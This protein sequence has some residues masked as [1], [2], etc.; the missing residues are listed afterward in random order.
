MT[1]QLYKVLRQVTTGW[2]LAD[3]RAQNLTKQQC[4]EVLNNIS[5]L[6][7]RSHIYFR[8]CSCSSP[9][10]SRS[11]FTRKLFYGLLGVF[12]INST[13]RSLH[14]LIEY[15][16]LLF[17]LTFFGSLLPFSHSFSTVFF[18]TFLESLFWTFFCFYF[19][20]FCLLS[21]ILSSRKLRD[22]SPTWYILPT[23]YSFKSCFLI[24]FRLLPF[25]LFSE[26]TFKVFT[27]LGN[28]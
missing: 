5:I 10:F 11:S 16:L 2:E 23:F 1:E 19:F 12:V 7:T 18:F 9:A 27:G 28:I 26:V 24:R 21:S 25:L 4:D 6:L 8:T 14:S 3:D 22:I 20:L 17:F 15:F 13:Y